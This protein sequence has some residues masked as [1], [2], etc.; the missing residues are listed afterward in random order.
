[1]KLAN[2][3]IDIP[4][5]WKHD[6]LL[7]NKDGQTI[8]IIQ[9]SRGIIPDEYWMHDVDMKDYNGNSIRSNL[10]KYNYIY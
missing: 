2:W 4:E 10:V 5:Y 7:R 1:M 8:A 6:K 3:G 9:S